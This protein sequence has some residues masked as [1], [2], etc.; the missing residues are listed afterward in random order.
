M[1]RIVIIMSAALSLTASAAFAEGSKYDD[2]QCGAYLSAPKIVPVQNIEA[3][4]GIQDYINVQ[5]YNLL[6]QRLENQFGGYSIE[7]IGVSGAGYKGTYSYAQFLRNAENLLS[8]I[9]TKTWQRL[10]AVYG[11]THCEHPDPRLKLKYNWTNGEDICVD[12]GLAALNGQL[13]RRETNDDKLAA[14]WQV[15]FIQAKTLS[16]NGVINSPVQRLVAS[17]FSCDTRNIN[18]ILSE[19]SKQAEHLAEYCKILQ[20]MERR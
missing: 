18:K 3:A 10:A 5:R 14:L 7:T 16:A 6:A 17:L 19:N 8:H 2:W 12:D 9:D 13:N 11:R 15:L 1:K 20:K 4:E